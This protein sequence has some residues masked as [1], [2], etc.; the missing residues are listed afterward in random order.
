[1]SQCRESAGEGHDDTLGPAVA[2]DREAIVR[3][4]RDVHGSQAP[5]GVGRPGGSVPVSSTCRYTRSYSAA[6]ARCVK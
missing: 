5:D 2:R 4:E 6:I 1:M 3:R